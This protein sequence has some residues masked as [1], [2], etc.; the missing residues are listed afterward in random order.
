MT[1]SKGKMWSLAPGTRGGSLNTTKEGKGG[2]ERDHV[3]GGERTLAEMATG[4][5]GGFTTYF[6][7]IPAIIVVGVIMEG[8]KRYAYHTER[9]RLPSP[10]AKGKR[11][12]HLRVQR[13]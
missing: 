4:D 8:G 6:V 12:T 1:R 9:R 3:P 5:G 11:G 13:R 7:P 2:E 10:P